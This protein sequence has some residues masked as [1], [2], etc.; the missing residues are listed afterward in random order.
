MLSSTV[1]DADVVTD[2]I[3]FFEI[4]HNNNE[5]IPQWMLTLQ[6]ISC[7]FGTLSWLSVATDGR[8]VYWLKAAL[9]WSIVILLFIIY[10]PILFLNENIIKKCLGDDSKVYNFIFGLGLWMKG[11]LTEPLIDSTYYKPSFSSS[12]LLLFFG[13]LLEDIPQFIVTFIIE[14]KIRSDDPTGRIS[15]TA[16]LNLTLAIF[17]DIL[18]KIA[19]ALD[20]LNDVHNVGYKYKKWIK[21]HTDLI[22]SLSVAGGNRILSASQDDTIK[23]WNITKGKFKQI[24]E[25]KCGSPVYDAVAIG[26]SEIMAAYW[27]DKIHVLS[28]ET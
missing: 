18:H 20:L 2:L 15:Q 22:C 13:I 12:T 11:H 1:A 7:I 19:E 26:S 9:L 28:F 23:L 27:D 6:L 16:T 21:A 3:Y 8:L 10:V 14:D 17:D 25:F 5:D 24:C 4:F